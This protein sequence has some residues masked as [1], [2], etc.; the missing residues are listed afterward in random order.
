MK[1][2]PDRVRYLEG[3]ADSGFR[4]VDSEEVSF[5][6]VG[7]NRELFTISRLVSQETRLQILALWRVLAGAE[8]C[9]HSSHA[10]P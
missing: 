5:A 9:P 7:G 4:N 8:P 10:F 2:F 3:G 1:C 6:I